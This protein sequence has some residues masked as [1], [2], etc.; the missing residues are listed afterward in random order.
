MTLGK[1]QSTATCVLCFEEVL[2]CLG[3]LEISGLCKR[4]C[5]TL[6]KAIEPKFAS[7]KDCRHETDSQHPAP[8][9]VI[10]NVGV[11]T[12]TPFHQVC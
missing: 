8:V 7:S 5:T 3:H 9:K 12:A 1:R 10:S 4:T 11:V 6:S 2:Q